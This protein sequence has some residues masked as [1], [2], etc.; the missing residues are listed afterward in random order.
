MCQRHLRRLYLTGNQVKSYISQGSAYK[1]GVAPA[2]GTFGKRR[3]THR[4]VH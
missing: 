3:L 4:L 2:G 1:A